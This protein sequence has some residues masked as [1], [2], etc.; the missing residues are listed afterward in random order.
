MGNPLF[1]FLKAA[2]R[3]SILLSGGTCIE[4]GIS[5]G[6]LSCVEAGDEL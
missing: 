3:I 6:H 5:K 4:K 2:T 1:W